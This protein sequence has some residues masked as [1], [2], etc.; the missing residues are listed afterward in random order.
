[1]HLKELHKILLGVSKCMLG[2]YLSGTG[3][4]KHCVTRLVKLIDASADVVPLEDESVTDKIK[5]NEAIILGYPTQFS[6][7]PYMIRDFIQTHASL[8][9][10]KKMICVA[11]MG[12]F[13]GDG[14]GCAAR[15][16][17]KYGAVILG[18]VHIKMPDSIC[19]SKM[20]KK[21]VEENE[22]IIR[23]AD[24]KVKEAAERIRQG[25]YPAEG[26]TIFAHI[27]GLIGQRLWF[28]KKTAGYTDQLKINQDCVGCGKCAKI[29]PM[30]NITMEN[31][32]P[33]PGGKCT[34]CYRC[35][36]NCPQKAITLL[37]SKV[38]LQYKFEDSSNLT[39][40]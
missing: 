3:N 15:L 34:M 1:M 27:A 32:R 13:S 17:K 6:N 22:K 40:M 28:Y 10:G 33:H 31:G 21:S 35:I 20:L 36:C 19:D 37:G 38:I 39:K 8:W 7:A 14:A 4:T 11:T 24:E 2:I 9:K 23:K 25:D 5:R 30:K 12:A 29:C 16:L 26:L 18:G